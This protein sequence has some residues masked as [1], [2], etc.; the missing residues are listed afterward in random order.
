MK[1][2]LRLF[3]SL[4]LSV[5]VAV[6]A[7]AGAPAK[8]LSKGNLHKLEVASMKA[9][10]A[11]AK[12]ERAGNSLKASRR[13]AAAGKSINVLRTSTA[14]APRPSVKSVLAAATDIPTIYGSVVYSDLWEE[15]L[16]GLYIL[17]KTTG[18]DFTS[19]IEGVYGQNG[20]VILDDV[21]YGAGIITNSGSFVGTLYEG[22][23]LTSGEKVFQYAST[24]IEEAPI[25][26]AYDPVSGK[27]YG[28][29]YNATGNGYRLATIT[30]N[31]D[32]T[33]TV[34]EIGALDGAWNSIAISSTGQIYGI[35]L[36]GTTAITGST[37]VK[38]D[39]ATAAVTEVGATGVV[40]K[41]YS[42]ATMDLKTDRLYWAIS[43][44]D[45][46]G[47][48]TE[49][50][51]ATGVATKL[52][53]FP[54][55][56]E[57]CGLAIPAPK[58]AGAPAA[59]TNLKAEF[60]NGSLAGT[61]SF[62]AP[63]VNNDGSTGT[64][65]L[66]YH[67]L[68]NGTEV[69][70][71]TTSYGASVSVNVTLTASG[72]TNIVAYVTNTVGDGAKE[73]VNFYAGYGAPAAPVVTLTATATTFNVSWT[74]VTTSADGGY[75]NPANVTYDVTRYPGAVKVAEG[76]TATSF[77]EPAIETE[78]IGKFYYTVVAKADGMVS[79][80]GTSNTIMTGSAALP[81]ENVF[82]SQADFDQFTVI[83]ANNDSKSWSYNA[84]PAGA[85]YL[86]NT[87][88]DADDWLISLPFKFEKGKAYTF[89][90]DTWCQSASY[91][92]KLEV[93]MGKE[94]SAAGMT[95]TLF[96]PT[97][98]NQL[99]S[100]RLSVEKVITVEETGI[101]FIGF[102]AISE[103]DNYYLF[104]GNVKV[105]AGVGDNA[106]AAV[107]DF[108]VTP[109][110]SGALNATIT[111]KAPTKD[112]GGNDLTSLDKIELLQGT[113]VIKTFDSVTPGQALSY[114]A[115][116][117]SADDYTFTAIPYNAAGSGERTSATVFIGV[118]YPA[119]PEWAKIEETATP[120]TVTVSWAAVTT[121]EAGLP[122]PAGSVVYDLYEFQGSSRVAVKEGLTT[123]SYTFEPTLG[124]QQDFVQC[125]VFAR[126]SRGEGE[127][128]ITDMIVVGA[129][130][131]TYV[132]SIAD[133]HLA[134]PVAVGG[135]AS[136][137]IYTDASFSDVSS[138]DGDN[139]FLGMK[140]QY[141][142]YYGILELGRFDVSAIE[143]PA[144]TFFTYALSNDDANTIAVLVREKG[145]TDDYTQ[146]YNTSIDKLGSDG[147]VGVTVD[148]S[149]Y[150]GKVFDIQI[151]GTIMAYQIILFD[152][153]R[154]KNL[155]DYDL[156]IELFAPEKVKAG[157]EFT[158]TATVTNEGKNPTTR[159]AIAF[160]AN[161]EECGRAPISAGIA[162]GASESQS[163]KV[164]LSPI[165]EEPVTYT[166][167]LTWSKDLDESNNTSNAVVVTPVANNMPRPTDLKAE[168]VAEGVKLTWDEPDL[169]NVSAITT[170][171]FEEGV[172]GDMAFEGW[173]MVDGDQ[174]P[175]GGFQGTDIPGI[176]PGQTLASFFIFEAPEGNPTFE[177]HSGNKYL[178]T[179][180]RY[181]DGKI[182]DWAISPALSG[183]EQ[184]ISFWAK[185]YSDQYPE[186]IEIYYST[187]SVTPADFIKVGQT[188]ANISS[189][190]TEYTATLPAGAKHFAIRSCA[191]GSF[192]LMLD[193]I[194]FEGDEKAQLTIQGY[195]VW[196][197]GV[198]ITESPVGD[199]EYI[200]ATATDG[201]HTYVVTAVYANGQSGASN[202]ATIAVSAL[203]ELSAGVVI[204]AGKGLITVKGAEGLAVS[205]VAVD[206]KVLYS[207]E[208]D[209]SVAVLP[210]VYVVKAGRKVAK[211]I[212]K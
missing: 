115:T 105:S 55:E 133:G 128:Q 78:G 2:A 81:Y 180:F 164:T 71:G 136:W 21:Y 50:N 153:I 27:S 16:T 15:D 192:M 208:G 121:D 37:L 210:G 167:T 197:D 119:A 146:I 122:L 83:D 13:T 157:S 142:N 109:D 25:G 19:V 86:Y 104:V 90:F 131:T 98:I 9:S 20:G 169:S 110:A 188:Y 22:Y 34:T 31:T 106:P 40:A 26:F 64:G 207:A 124:A 93:K 51:L 201:E 185:S 173:T 160:F 113:E 143:N 154:I 75:F 63:T 107:T 137:S 172:A 193:D 129:P 152:N 92:E 198:C 203:D 199:L 186:T 139:G 82:D 46:T 76:I 168:A 44:A 195:N 11:S 145:S 52:V 190:W 111:F 211:V 43:P 61:V 53:H 206:G 85:R 95:T 163:I 47:W 147:W 56:A 141:Q 205:V 148:L 41:Y 161:G 187:G 24:A 100:A 166:A 183:N 54:G 135:N 70:T 39:R 171:D 4:L 209:A 28:I 6:T 69:A 174:S 68:A 62:T 33:I 200:D 32:Q 67:V 204:S 66:T 7:Y 49:V 84:S 3:F 177:A 126:T 189:T 202:E 74:A 30:F 112:F 108:K 89:S 17:P 97:T 38:I 45:E 96:E 59:V 118:N 57:V 162:S 194:T 150:K 91:P 42:G 36:D 151:K 125:C 73:S 138:Q 175:V 114:T 35:R 103:K 117:T 87:S 60:A 12:A 29:F 99:N 130:Y 159:G 65:S 182:D 196:R 79:A 165:A 181:D 176:T 77:S 5:S 134:H 170:E 191:E 178:A 155:I 102:H 88:A 116:V 18:A 144:L 1:N 179:M 140:G 101:Y 72:N 10:P 149:A 120:G 48:L 123:T 14:E 156:S 23:N 8:R 80:T 58:A 184:T 212:V 127:G 158:L 132:E 94:C